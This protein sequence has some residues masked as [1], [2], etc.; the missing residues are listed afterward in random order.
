MAKFVNAPLVIAKDAAGRDRYLYAGSPLPDDLADGE[1]ER[2]ADF[3][4][5]DA[6]DPNADLSAPADEPEAKPARKSSK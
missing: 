4:T 6:V 3:L 2:L 1:A 5:G